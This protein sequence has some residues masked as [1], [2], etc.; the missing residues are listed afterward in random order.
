[1]LTEKEQLIV[2]A[3]YWRGQ[4][5]LSQERV[6]ALLRAVDEM[7]GWIA[8]IKAERIRQD[9]KWGEQNH[10]DFKWLSILVEEVGELAK[11]ILENDPHGV[12]ELTHCAAVCV[13]WMDAINNRAAL[14]S[15]EGT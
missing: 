9:A 14:K 1:M 15:K 8:V 5:D 3:A 10:D 12:E 4:F 11:A 2:D 6:S 7:P 13:Q